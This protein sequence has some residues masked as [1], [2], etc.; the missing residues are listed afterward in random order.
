MR[1]WKK[2]YITIKMTKF[3]TVTNII[4]VL[5]KFAHTESVSPGFV[6]KTKIKLET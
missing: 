6:L 3:I 1:N 4:S 5:L 2:F